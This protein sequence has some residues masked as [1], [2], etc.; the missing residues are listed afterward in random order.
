MKS[1]GSGP[2]QISYNISLLKNDGEELH[3][4]ITF[5]VDEYQLFYWK[6]FAPV[7]L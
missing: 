1:F 2:A 7:F 5:F 4:I 3:M 6:M